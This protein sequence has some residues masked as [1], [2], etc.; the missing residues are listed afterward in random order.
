[1]NTEENAQNRKLPS[2]FENRFNRLVSTFEREYERLRPEFGK[3]GFKQRVHERIGKQLRS[4]PSRL[5]NPDGQLDRSRMGGFIE[6]IELATLPARLDLWNIHAGC[7]Y[8]LAAELA[9]ERR[10]IDRAWDLLVEASLYLGWVLS[11]SRGPDVYDHQVL[12]HVRSNAGR[13]ASDA[14]HRGTN[15]M[16][17]AAYAHV[18]ACGAFPTQPKAVISIKSMLKEKFP[19]EAQ[20]K[21]PEETIMGWLSDMPD[22]EKYFDSLKKKKK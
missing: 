11:V 21:A 5:L 17:E 8:C 2:R 18:K 7:A 10:V 22:R 19:P 14:R 20:L 15:A 6:E 12:Q 1:M 3:D 13:K 16:K 9:Y 4:D